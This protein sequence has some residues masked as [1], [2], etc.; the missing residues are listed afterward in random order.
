MKRLGVVAEGWD[1]AFRADVAREPADIVNLGYVI[2]VIEDAVERAATLTRAWQL[3]NRLLV[4]SALVNVKGWGQSVVPFGDGIITRIG[5]FQKEFSQSE[6]RAYIESTLNA[7]ALPAAL[8]VYY[9]F[10]DEQ[11]QQQYLASKYR[12]HAAPRKRGAEVRFDAHRELLE[13]VIERISDL[14]RLPFDDELEE[15]DEVREKLGSIKRAFALIRRVS[16]GET[17]EN[18]GEQQTQ[19]M[20]VYLALSR[21]GQRPKVSQ[22]PLRIQRDIKAFFKSYSRACEMADMLLFRA[23]HAEAIDDACKE[24]RIGKLL[25][26]ALYVHRSALESLEPI[27]RIYEGCASSYLGEI[28]GAN[29]VK[30]HRHSGKLSYLAY[31]NFDRDPHPAL[32]RSVKLSLRTREIQCFDYANSDNP[33]ILHRKESFLEPD[34]PSYDKFAKLTKQEEDCGLLTDTSTIGTRDGWERRL[35]AEGFKLRGHRLTRLKD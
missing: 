2:N 27:L 15:A 5:T 19:D 16:D 13:S 28:E 9:V 1:P 23:G 14:G 35:A 33:P 25:P 30:F 26:N 17:W 20:L 12:R 24:S 7:D 34:H 8:G 21:F 18:L 29:I 22:L 31:P 32:L 6:L 3:A 11:L 10:K 4:V